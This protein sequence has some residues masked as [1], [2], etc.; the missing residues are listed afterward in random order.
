MAVNARLACVEVS[1]ADEIPIVHVMNR[2]LRRCFLL[3]GL[4][5][6]RE[7]LCHRKVWLDE[8]LIH[9]VE[10]GMQIRPTSGERSARKSDPSQRTVEFA[11]FSGRFDV[12]DVGGSLCRHV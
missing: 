2:T 8:Q 12:R 4:S 7:K 9:Q 1:A 3:V 10:I 5:V 11:C 6:Q